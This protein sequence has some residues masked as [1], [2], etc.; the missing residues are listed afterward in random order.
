[1]YSLEQELG[2]ELGDECDGDYGGDGDDE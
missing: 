2:G 1:M